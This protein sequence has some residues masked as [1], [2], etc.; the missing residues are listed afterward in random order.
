MSRRNILLI[1]APLWL[2]LL[3]F[4]AK[5]ISLNI[6]ANAGLNDYRAQAY[7]D[8]D[9]AFGHLDSVNV[10]ESY[11]A[12]FNLGTTDLQTGRLEEA[13]TTLRRALELAP[14]DAQCPVRVNL[15]VT[16][17][18]LGDQATESGD[19]QQAT[20]RYTEVVELASQRDC[21]EDLMSAVPRLEQLEMEAQSKLDDESPSPT[22]DPTSSSEPTPEQQD[23][24]ETKKEELE[25]R[26]EESERQRQRD[27]Q[28]QRDMNESDYG[29]SSEGRTW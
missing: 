26:Q 24:T 15:G 18:A 28:N 7:A 2:I 19:D 13:E 6:F 12:H 8:A 22:A 25:K 20:E 9:S 27:R 16:I 14:D 1:S 29:S 23:N 3:L 21:G 5:L 17:M 11:I 4:A 10:V